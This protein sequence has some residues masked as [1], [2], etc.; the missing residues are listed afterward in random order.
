MLECVV[1]LELRRRLAPDEEILYWTDK[2]MMKVDFIMLKK[3]G[4][5]EAMQGSWE[6][7]DPMTRKREV[8][9]LQK[10]LDSTGCDHGTI[11]TWAEMGSRT[12]EDNRIEVVNALDWL[13]DDEGSRRL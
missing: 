6:M 4:V 12:V 11:I 7:K 3:T 13:L 10:C 2:G 9:S 1:Y 8:R 5:K